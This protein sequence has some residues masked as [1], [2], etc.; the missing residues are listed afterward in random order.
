MEVS[1][2]QNK[3]YWLAE[4]VIPEMEASLIVPLLEGIAFKAISVRSSPTG[5]G[6]DV[7]LLVAMSIDLPSSFGPFSLMPG[8]AL[9][10]A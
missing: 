6:I 5:I 4:L 1:S 9:S 7:V 3:L 8:P 10:K 2:N